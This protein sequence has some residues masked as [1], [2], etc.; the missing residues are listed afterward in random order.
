MT[1]IWGDGGVKQTKGRFLPHAPIDSETI[2]QK[3]RRGSHQPDFRTIA[4]KNKCTEKN[5]G[6]RGSVGFET[7]FFTR[8]RRETEGKKKSLLRGGRKS[9]K[10]KKKHGLLYN[11]LGKGKGK[12]EGGSAPL[13]PS[14]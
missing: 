3:S 2:G 13:F 6:V 1:K 11:R 5:E 14:N 10:K 7:Y 4:G 9:K 12:D 8:Q